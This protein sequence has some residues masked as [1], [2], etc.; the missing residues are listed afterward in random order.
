MKKW[1]RPVILEI[2][3]GMEINLYVC[4]ELDGRSLRE[5]C[6]DAIPDRALADQAARAAG[7]TSARFIASRAAIAPSFAGGVA[8]SDP[9]NVPIAVRTPLRITMPVIARSPYFL[10]I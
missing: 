3:V 10:E 9:P 6:L 8:A 7:S 5:L 1:Q 2:Q 4:A